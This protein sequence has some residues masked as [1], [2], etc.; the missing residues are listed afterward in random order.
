MRIEG[1]VCKRKDSRYVAGRSSAWRKVKCE[2]REQLIMAG[3][4]RPGRNGFSSLLLGAYDEAGKLRYAGRVK[5]GWNAETERILGA[6][7]ESLVRKTPAYLDPPYKEGA[8]WVT[9]KLVAEV[10]YLE[11][12]KAGALRQASFKGLCITDAREVRGGLPG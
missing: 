8:Y 2:T 6:A 11:R 10:A 5:T 1:I 7:L 4:T 9:P 12:T 3:F